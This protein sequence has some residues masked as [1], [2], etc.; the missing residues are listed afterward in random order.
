MG[1]IAMIVGTRRVSTNLDTCV[2]EDRVLE[3]LRCLLVTD[4]TVDAKQNM[5]V[6]E[7]PAPIVL[8]VSEIKPKEETLADLILK[9]Q[10][11]QVV[12]TKNQ[13]DHLVVG[14]AQA[15]QEAHTQ[16]KIHGDINPS[17]FIVNMKGDKVKIKLVGLESSY[18]L[19]EDESSMIVAPNQQKGTVGYIAPEVSTEGR[20]SFKSDIFSFGCILNDLSVAGLGK[21]FDYLYRQM[22]KKAANK[23]PELR[24]SLEAT[25]AFINSNGFKELK[26]AGERIGRY[27]MV[28]L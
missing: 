27:R 7:Q 17:Q 19:K 18:V 3:Q 10:Q 22:C 24:K 9:H 8:V 28:W 15:L 14:C 25:I 26:E 1:L 12:L 2:E 6:I 21:R 20:Y 5:T 16:R 11:E 23:N 13:I 4:N